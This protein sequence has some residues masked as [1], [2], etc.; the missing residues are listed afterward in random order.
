MT[1]PFSTRSLAASVFHSSAAARTSSSRASAPTV[2]YRSYSDQ[3]LV[4]PPVICIPKP[5]WA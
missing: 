1:Y 3:V 4:D 5:V 2:L